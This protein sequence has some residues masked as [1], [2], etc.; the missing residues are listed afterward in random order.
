M[1]NEIEIPLVDEGISGHTCFL[2]RAAFCN[3]YSLI[4]QQNKK[5]Q[6]KTALYWSLKSER[7][8]FY[9]TFQCHMVCNFAALPPR[10]FILPSALRLKGALS[11]AGSIDGQYQLVAVLFQVVGHLFDAAGSCEGRPDEGADLRSL[12][13]VE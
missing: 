5:D 3:V 4:L 8:V 2:Q 11:G 12:D 7:I 9:L 13:G 10:R 6:Y 1:N